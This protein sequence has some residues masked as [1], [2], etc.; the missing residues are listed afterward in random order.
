MR[1]VDLYLTLDENV[2]IHIADEDDNFIIYGKSEDIPVGIL[3]KEVKTI[4]LAT[5]KSTSYLEIVIEG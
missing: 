3:Y 2:F 4:K 5:L 1:V